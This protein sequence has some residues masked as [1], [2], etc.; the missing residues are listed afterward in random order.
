[1]KNR[2]ILIYLVTALVLFV[3]T[4]GIR[5]PLGNR[6][7]LNLSEA[8]IMLMMPHLDC[9]MALLISAGTTAAADI[10]VGSGQYVIATFIIKGLEGFVTAWLGS[11]RKPFLLIAAADA[12]ICMLGY[13]VTDMLLYG[14]WQLFLLSLGQNMLQT[15]ISVALAIWLHPIIQKTMNSK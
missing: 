9:G 10:L 1:M 11:K 15:A 12:L 7:Y 4:A 2:R 6:G 8:V 13:A 5:Y 3:A 14:G